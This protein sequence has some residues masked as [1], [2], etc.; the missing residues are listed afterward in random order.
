MIFNV[1][2]IRDDC[3]AHFGSLITN[4]SDD[5]AKR[6]FQF[7]LSNSHGIEHDC[8][9]DFTL[10]RVGTFDSSTG[11]LRCESPTIIVRGDSFGI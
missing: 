10:Y 3:A 4:I 11:E 9:G 6:D 5:C 8:P 1:Y 2:S 7:Q